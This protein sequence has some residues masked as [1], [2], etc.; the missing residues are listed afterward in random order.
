MYHISHIKEPTELMTG[1]TIYNNI[2]KLT[3]Q[4]EDNEAV[5]Y[6]VDDQGADKSDIE[7]TVISN[8]DL[9]K[10]EK[11]V[12]KY[13]VYNED[14]MIAGLIDSGADCTTSGSE[15]FEKFKQYLVK[16]SIKAITLVPAGA[17]NK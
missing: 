15:L 9:S 11:I 5:Q 6:M 7:Y 13:H 3:K 10:L 8:G 17:G 12:G 1:D 2:C 16:N 4:K 14:Y